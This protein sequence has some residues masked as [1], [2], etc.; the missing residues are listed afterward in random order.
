ML[1][2][3]PRDRELFC[4]SF[5]FSLCDLTTPVTAETF[6]SFVVVNRRHKRHVQH[7][8]AI[9]ISEHNNQ[10]ARRIHERVITG[11]HVNYRAITG[12]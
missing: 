1:R 6:R 4:C 2:L 9:V 8:C 12:A 10:S 3:R 7:T 5:Q 11:W